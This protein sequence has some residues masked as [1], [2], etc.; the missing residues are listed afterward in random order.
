MI[1][2]TLLFLA[3]SIVLISG[4]S[5]I[6][7]ASAIALNTEKI[8]SITQTAHEPVT[9][10]I[11]DGIPTEISDGDADS[12]LSEQQM[13]AFVANNGFITSIPN[14]NWSDISGIPSG[15][16]D[17][18]DNVGLTSVNWNQIQSIPSGFADGV[19]NVS[20]GIDSF[21]VTCSR[22][23]IF[24]NVSCTLQ[25]PA[26]YGVTSINDGS[27]DHTFLDSNRVSCSNSINV[28]C[29]ATCVK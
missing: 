22:S 24:G 29:S 4:I 12:Q 3:L 8:D 10:G 1:N 16:A 21:G 2:K 27:G 23:G 26:T 15:F 9:W 13:D 7:F 18:T 14:T 17:G 20:M 19:D 25:C 5:A 28:S 6:K 11:L